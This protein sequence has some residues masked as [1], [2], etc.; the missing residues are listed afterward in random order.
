MR[1]QSTDSVWVMPMESVYAL[2]TSQLRWERFLSASKSMP[3]T[4]SGT[5]VD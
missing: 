3:F 4:K 2:K 1:L 5:Q